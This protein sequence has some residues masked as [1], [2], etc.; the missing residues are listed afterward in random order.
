VKLH[1]NDEAKRAK[2]LAKKPRISNM[3]YRS[4]IL[5]SSLSSY[6]QVE[7]EGAAQCALNEE[8]FACFYNS[9]VRPLRAYL[10]RASGNPTL[11]DDLVQES[12]LRF[13]CARAPWEEGE[14]ACRRYLF[15]IGTNLLR[16][17]WR[18]PTGESL[19]DVPM[20]RL[21]SVNPQEI[22]HLDSDAL[23]NTALAHLRPVERQL[24]WLAHAEGMTHKEISEITG[25]GTPLIR[26][27]LFRSRHKLARA[28]R[29]EMMILGVRS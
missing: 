17:H 23:L 1:F 12:Y 3:N 9:T 14:T 16:D 15:R 27:K 2:L 6:A 20:Q 5:E 13:L 25:M 29:Q 10:S 21:P 7:G 22:E 18:R 24:L 26:L 19:E 11:A 8:A 28:L 4:A